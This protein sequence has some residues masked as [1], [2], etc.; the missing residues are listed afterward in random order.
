MKGVCYVHMHTQIEGE[1]NWHE[2]DSIAEKSWRLY[3]TDFLFHSFIVFV[4]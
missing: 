4:G 1:P 2:V 3:S